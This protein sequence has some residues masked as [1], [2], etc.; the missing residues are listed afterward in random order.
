MRDSAGGVT[1][2]WRLSAY[3]LRARTLVALGDFVSVLE[4]II[5]GRADLDATIWR[6]VGD[7]PSDDGTASGMTQR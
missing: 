1:K 3:R 2:T 7:K 6:R 5:Q 4:Q